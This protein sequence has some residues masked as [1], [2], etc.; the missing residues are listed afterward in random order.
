M[1][2][3]SKKEILAEVLSRFGPLRIETILRGL[4]LQTALRDPLA[5][6]RHAMLQVCDVWST[7]ED[8]KLNRILMVEIHR[9]RQ[10]PELRS[11]LLDS[12]QGSPQ[13]VL[14]LLRVAVTFLMEKGI[15]RKADVDLVVKE[16]LFPILHM[17]L[18]LPDVSGQFDPQALRQFVESH[19]DFFFDA[20]KPR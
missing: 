2:Y 13:Q 3:S 19:L 7:P 9:I 10:D 6:V 11:S 5:F 20:M 17:R 4:D 8:W 14:E 1:H 12:R 15:F 16:F 18:T